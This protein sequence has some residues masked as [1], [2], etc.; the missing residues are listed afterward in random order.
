MKQ[1]ILLCAIT[2]LSLMFFSCQ[3]DD[4]K[5][6]AVEISQA[7]FQAFF[8]A[9][10]GL[11]FYVEDSLSVNIGFPG[12]DQ[13]YDFSGI[14]LPSAGEPLSGYVL[15]EHV[16]QLPDL[17]IRRESMGEHRGLSD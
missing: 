6:Q 9:G 13:M 11:D 7:D 8:S 15:P 3:K 17:P 5:N 14:S 4:D 2:L 10:K 12:A 16:S 1:K